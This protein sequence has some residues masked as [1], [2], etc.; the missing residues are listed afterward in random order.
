VQSSRYRT[1]RPCPQLG[2]HHPT[3]TSTPTPTSGSCATAWVN[4]I[5]YVAGNE[6]SYGGD[7][8]TA[9]QWNYDEA[10][11]GAAGAWTSDGA[12]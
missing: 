11:G 12:C 5:A 4:N 3:P 6:V 8:W 10:P 1:S 7:D 2:T 9:S